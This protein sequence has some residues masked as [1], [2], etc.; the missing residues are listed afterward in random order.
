LLNRGEDVNQLTKHHQSALNYASQH[1]Q[2][3]VVQLMLGQGT[4]IY[5]RN[6]IDYTVLMHTVSM[7]WSVQEDGEDT[8]SDA[9][10]SR[11]DIPKIL[12][13]V[14]MLLKAGTNINARGPSS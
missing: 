9:Q 1:L 10:K 12:S 5:V 13:I 14:T 8:C 2:P 7:G 6:G 11:E 3:H 4:D